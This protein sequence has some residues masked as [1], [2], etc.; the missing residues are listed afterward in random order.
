MHRVLDMQRLP[1]IVHRAIH[2]DG[3]QAPCSH[4]S[5]GGDIHSARCHFPENDRWARR[6]PLAKKGLRV[7]MGIQRLSAVSLEDDPPLGSGVVTWT[8]E[9]LEKAE[10]NQFERWRESW[11]VMC[12]GLS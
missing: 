7:R 8:P 1:G 9:S 6:I 10:I 12:V 3:A 2:P 4:S 11:L 5:F